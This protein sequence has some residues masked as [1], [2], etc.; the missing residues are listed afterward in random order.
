MT[1]LLPVRNLASGFFSTSLWGGDT[2]LVLRICSRPCVRLS[3]QRISEIRKLMSSIIRRIYMTLEGLY[4]AT[5]LWVPFVILFAV[6][7][8]HCSPHVKF[9][10]FKMSRY[11]IIAIVGIQLLVPDS[12]L[13]LRALLFDVGTRTFLLIEGAELLWFALSAWRTGTYQ[14]LN[15]P[16]GEVS[17]GLLIWYVISALLY[18][19]WLILGVSFAFTMVPGM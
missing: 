14:G 4:R 16:D 3:F 6:Q 13:P 11:Y 18:L 10:L 15:V 19:G 2:S 17:L 9:S 8:L 5:W 12:H 7:G 1:T